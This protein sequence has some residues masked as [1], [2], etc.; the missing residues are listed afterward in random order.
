MAMDVPG[1]ARPHR[2]AQLRKTVDRVRPPAANIV[3]Q[4]R[5]PPRL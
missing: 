3:E 1:R 2:S 5:S 4:L